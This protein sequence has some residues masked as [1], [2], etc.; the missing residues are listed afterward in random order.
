MSATPLTDAVAE[1]VNSDS[2]YTDHGAY[3]RMYNHAME[4]EIMLNAAHAELSELQYIL[5]SL[6]K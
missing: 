3:L 6:E 2:E 4:L 5:G 1:S